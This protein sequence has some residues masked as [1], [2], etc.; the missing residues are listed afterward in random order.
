MEEKYGH[1]PS[2]TELY[3]EEYFD[4]IIQEWDL[5]GKE[6]AQ[7]WTERMNKR[8]QRVSDKLQSVKERKENIDG[9]MDKIESQIDELESMG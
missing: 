7:S 6:R 9:E 5:V 4:D 3:F 8:L 2:H 1:V